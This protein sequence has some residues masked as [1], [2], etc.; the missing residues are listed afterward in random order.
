MG[1]AP[2][3]TPPTGAPDVSL[4]GSGELVGGYGG[5]VWDDS[6]TTAEARTLRHGYYA[7]T[8]YVDAQVGKVLDALDRLGLTEKTIVVLWGDHGW[9]LGDL[10][11]WGKHTTYEFSLRSPLVVRAPGLTPAEGAV[12]RN[13]VESVDIY[14]TLA[15]VSGLPVPETVDGESLRPHLTDPTR[16]DGEEETAFGYWRRGD[17]WGKTIRTDRYRLT[18]WTNEEKERTQIE[19]Y[20]HW[21]D[22]HE[23]ENV[24][25]A[26]SSVVQ[27]LLERMRDDNK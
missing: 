2:R 20:D 23:T 10:G 11:M 19:L 22:P 15:D 26:R 24:A 7:A 13:V 17:W 27:R 25:E 16:R 3:P 14:P 12:A 4:H 1:L 18:R 9:H 8:S 6:I 21:V 5:V